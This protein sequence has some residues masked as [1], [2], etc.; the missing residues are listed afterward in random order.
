[1]MQL[2][3]NGWGTFFLGLAPIWILLAILG[4]LYW[5]SLLSLIT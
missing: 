1:M 2:L 4:I 5:D 3:D